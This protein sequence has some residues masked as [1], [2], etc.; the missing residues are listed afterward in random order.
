MTRRFLV[1]GI[2]VLAGSSAAFAHHSYGS[3]FLDRTASVE[4]EIQ[5]L[6]FANPHVVL[7]I[8]TR[9]GSL[10]T[11]TWGPAY[12][13]ERAGVTKTTLKIGDHVIVSGAPPRDPGA[14]ELMPVWEIRR[15]RDGWVWKHQRGPVRVASN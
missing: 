12:Q 8:R 15:P 7:Q 9:D 1:V 10:Y 5:Q 14:H 2:L 6:R 11:A 4:G 13:V 3:F